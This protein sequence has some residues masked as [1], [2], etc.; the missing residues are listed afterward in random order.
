MPIIK[1]AIKRD[2]QNK[3]R[4]LSNQSIRSAVK[5]SVKKVFEY[6]SAKDLDSALKSRNEAFS[7]LDKASRK[8]IIH[9]NNA[10][11]KKAKIS[12]W[13]NSIEKKSN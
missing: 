1:S 13:L 3:K 7:I 5:T 8:N 6:V 10:A 4:R 11:R 9:P 2:R 12:K